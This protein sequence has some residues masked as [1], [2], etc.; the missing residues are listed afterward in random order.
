MPPHGMYQAGTN[1]NKE[2]R[3]NGYNLMSTDLVVW[4]YSSCTKIFISPIDDLYAC[5]LL[6]IFRRCPIIMILTCLWSSILILVLL[7][8]CHSLSHFLFSTFSNSLS[9]TIISCSLLAIERAVTNHLS[10]PL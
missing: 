6:C 9:P 10:A 3:C 8:E 1:G 4:N 5:L 7:S 2:C